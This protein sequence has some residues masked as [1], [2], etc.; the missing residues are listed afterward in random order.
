[1]KV[2]ARKLSIPENP[3]LTAYK[4]YKADHLEENGCF[5]IDDEGESLYIHLKGS[6]FVEGG[7]WDVDHGDNDEFE[8]RLNASKS[9]RRQYIR[10]ETGELFDKQFQ[11]LRDE[12]ARLQRENGILSAKLDRITKTINN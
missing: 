1:M 4:W 11:I 8:T 2:R 10:R 12:I 9:D 6:T 7:D 3:H 5:I